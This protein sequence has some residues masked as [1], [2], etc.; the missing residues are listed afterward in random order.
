MPTPSASISSACFMGS[1][2]MAPTRA[3][4][5]SCRVLGL[6]PRTRVAVLR[7]VVISSFKL[8]KQGFGIWMKAFFQSKI[9]DGFAICR[10]LVAMSRSD[11]RHGR[12]LYL[13]SLQP[14]VPSPAWGLPHQNPRAAWQLCVGGGMTRMLAA[15]ARSRKLRRLG[16]RTNDPSL[17]R[18]SSRISRTVLDGG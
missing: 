8:L 14:T 11:K 9:Y 3:R 6:A 13:F 18:G 2:A 15:S 1:P 5:V 12:N 7:E 17:S 10:D 4:N 16:E